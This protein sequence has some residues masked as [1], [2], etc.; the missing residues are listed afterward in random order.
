MMEPH[1]LTRAQVE[2]IHDDLMRE[3][4]GLPGLRNE[5]ALEATLAR[6]INLFLHQ[7]ADIYD[8][9][10]AYAHGIVNNHPFFDGNKRTAFVVADVFLKRNCYAFAMSEPEAVRVM[11]ALA[12]TEITQQEFAEFIRKNCKKT[13]AERGW[14]KRHK[15]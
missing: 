9:A 6:P 14:L 2:I 15:R 3:H 4:G 13:V 8:L 12:S 5:T 11:V 7:K 10:A 1:W